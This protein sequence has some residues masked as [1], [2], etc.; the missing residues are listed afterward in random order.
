MWVF[1][2]KGKK[3]ESAGNYFNNEKAFIEPVA[4]YVDV[5]WLWWNR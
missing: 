4:W 5:S 1:A 3:F 2:Y